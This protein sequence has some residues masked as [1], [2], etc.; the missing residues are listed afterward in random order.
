MPTLNEP[1]V[2][3]LVTLT[4]SANTSSRSTWSRPK[5][6]P[7]FTFKVD[8]VQPKLEAYGTKISP[9]HCILKSFKTKS[10]YRDNPVRSKVRLPGNEWSYPDSSHIVEY[11]QVLLGHSPL[12]YLYPAGESH[13]LLYAV[14]TAFSN[15][16]PIAFS[17]DII[18]HVILQGVSRH[19]NNSPEEHR[20]L[21][22]TFADKQM[23]EIYR[24]DL[25]LDNLRGVAAAV[26]GIVDEFVA[27]MGEHVTPAYLKV[28][29]ADFSTTTPVDKTVAAIT[30]L[31][32]F[33]PY[34]DL[35]MGCACGFP[36]VTVTGS[37]LDWRTLRSKVI[38]IEELFAVSDETNL[39]WW[40]SKLKQ[41]VDYFI[42]AAE[43]NPDIECWKR[44]YKHI[45]TYGADTF[46]GWIGWLWPYIDP[47]QGSLWSRGTTFTT[48]NPMLENISDEVTISRHNGFGTPIDRDGNKIPD[49]GPRTVNM[50]Q[51]RSVSV[52]MGEWYKTDAAFLHTNQFPGGLSKVNLKIGN[53]QTREASTR[54]LDTMLVAGFIGVD[55]SRHDYCLTPQVGWALVS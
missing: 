29:Q 18:W 8:D 48:R 43:G 33:S 41:V 7:S 17:P 19:I 40:T 10:T 9:E 35:F 21:F 47:K 49:P 27:R 4:D 20:H 14:H 42:L 2:D 54:T 11:D 39:T 15:H 46:N 38:E 53:A 26:P 23:I 12:P 5:D 16:Y 52:C 25:S 22:V 44:M 37:V 51:S 45:S 34:F 6:P 24:P 36:Q 31:E 32:A 1:L 3:G 13:P 30:C 55:Q 28:F 50:S